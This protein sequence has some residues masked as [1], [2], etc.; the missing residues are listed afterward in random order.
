[1]K[2]KK[3]LVIF[4]ICSCAIFTFIVIT[5][6][7][8]DPFN[9]YSNS[10]LYIKNQRYANAGVVRTADYESIIL[11]GSL[12]EN[13]PLEQISDLFK[14]KFVKIANS[15]ATAYES[16]MYA[17]QAFKTHSV[18]KVLAPIDFFTFRGKPTRIHKRFEFPVYLFDNNTLNDLSLFSNFDTF[19]Y[20]LKMIGSKFLHLSFWDI[21]DDHEDL[22]NWYRTDKVNFNYKHFSSSWKNRTIYSKEELAKYK[23]NLLVDSF[24]KNFLELIKNNPN[25]QFYIY[26]PPYSALLYSQFREQSPEFIKDIIAF[27]KTVFESCLEY[28]N[29]QLFDF[30]IATSITTDSKNY[31]DLSH[32]SPKVDQIILKEIK[33]PNYYIVTKKN[34]LK[35]LSLFETHLYNFKKSQMILK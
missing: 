26:F 34:Y 9:I 14:S 12:T 24:N 25:T 19:V 15:G 17:N 3:W 29:V 8:V 23:V 30:Q 31:K 33:K 16:R 21:T 27:K 4:T 18:Q 6:V 7:I 13:L 22:F 10:G 5:N 11:G 2:H 28:K 32:F 20:S 35:K 1:M